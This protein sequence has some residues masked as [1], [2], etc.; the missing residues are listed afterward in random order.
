MDA[1]PEVF[2]RYKADND[3][4]A[5]WDFNDLIDDFGLWQAGK[6]PA[7]VTSKQIEALRI[8]AKG[9]GIYPY[10]TVKVEEPY[11]EE[12]YERPFLEETINVDYYT[13]TGKHVS[14]SSVRYRDPESGRFIK[15]P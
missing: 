4:K 6:R 13:K 10:E 2:E 1:F 11:E 8:E 9:I 15:R 5:D 7:G 3:P 14:Y 12:Y